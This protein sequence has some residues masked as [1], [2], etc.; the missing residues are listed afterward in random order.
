MSRR[1]KSRFI[2]RIEYAAY[3][4]VVG[5]V[6]RMSEERVRRWGA[7]LGTLARLV[8]RKRHQLALRNL[9]ETFPG[10]DPRELR[11]IANDCWRH[12]GRESLGYIRLQELPLADIAA[13]CEFHDLELVEEALARGKGV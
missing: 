2:Q 6:R 5:L 12:F 4:A 9:A 7:R 13:R 1:K 8:V 10:R 3:R 11:A